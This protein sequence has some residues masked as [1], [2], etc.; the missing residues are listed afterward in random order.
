MVCVEI[1]RPSLAIWVVD[2]DGRNHALVYD[3]LA[4]R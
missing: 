1:S 4:R 3:S 2:P